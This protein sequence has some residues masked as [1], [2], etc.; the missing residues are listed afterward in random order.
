MPSSATITLLGHLA[1]EVEVRQAG[2]YKVV[3]NSI[4]VTDKSKAGEVTTWY[5]VTFWGKDADVVS[6]WCGKGALLLI[7]G[8]LSTRTW[9]S[10]EGQDRVTPTVK[11]T[12]FKII[13]G[14]KDKAE[15]DENL[16]DR[17]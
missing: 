7:N 13:D 5:D 15:S 9:K 11:V 4:P 16:A 10:K 17:F 6:T 8:S 14:K 2:Q 12:S 3:N 1:K